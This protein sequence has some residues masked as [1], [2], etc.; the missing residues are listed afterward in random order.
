MRTRQKQRVTTDVL[1]SLD[2]WVLWFYLAEE[3]GVP[4]GNHRPSTG[5]H[6]PADADNGDR[7][8]HINH[9]ILEN[10][11]LVTIS[12]FILS[13][14]GAPCVITNKV[15]PCS[16]IYIGIA[17]FPAPGLQIRCAKN[18]TPTSSAFILNSVI[19]ESKLGQLFRAKTDVVKIPRSVYGGVWINSYTNAVVFFMWWNFDFIFKTS[20]QQYTFNPF[21]AFEIRSCICLCS[22]VTLAKAET[23]HGVL[24]FLEA[25]FHVQNSRTSAFDVR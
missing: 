10:I 23:P 1:E 12:Q 18:T 16:D 5:D 17:F 25:C 22:V 19:S 8:H 15:E 21:W 7:T 2:V 3:T 24:L 6:Y 14:V 4:G 20:L 13:I 9:L 11:I